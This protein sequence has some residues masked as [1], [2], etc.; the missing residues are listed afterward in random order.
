MEYR[1]AN[2]DEHEIICKQ[3][4][5]KSVLY[6]S[7]M[8]PII[9]IFLLACILSIRM[10]IRNKYDTAVFVISTLMLVLLFIAAVIFIVGLM[11]GFV[12]RIIYINCHKYKVA[13]CSVTGKDQRINPKHIHSYVTVGFQDGSMIRAEVTAKIYSLAET[14]KRAL[15]VKYDETEG[16]KDLPYEVAV[17]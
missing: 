16:K 14:G 11:K 12:K 7:I 1:E 4:R 15:L 8:A 3:I 17:L 6:V 13:E 5:S 9:P 2:S 10:M